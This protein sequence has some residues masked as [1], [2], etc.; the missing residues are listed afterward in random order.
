MVGLCL[1]PHLVLA[2]ILQKFRVRLHQLM[3]NAI[4]Q[5]RK[6]IWAVSSYGGRPTTDVFA[7]H[8]ELH[9]QQKK[10]KLEGSTNTL[11]GQFRCITF[12]LSRY[13]VGRS[14]PLP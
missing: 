4:V 1:L 5:I 3:P 10:I 14:S 12:H 6:F 7:M 2:E 9:Y 13:G 8:Y 11:A